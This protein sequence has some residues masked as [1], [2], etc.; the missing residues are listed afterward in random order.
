MRPDPAV[1]S[2]L[3]LDRDDVQSSRGGYARHVAS[4][5]IANPCASAV[6]ESRLA[7]VRAELAEDTELRMT[8]ARGEAIELA[9]E[10]SA[11]VDAVYVFGGDGTFN[12]VLNGIDAT[13]PVGFIPGG[14]TSVL[15]RALGLPKEPAAAARRV[16]KAARARR[17][18]VGRVNG[19]RFGFGAGVGIDAE[20]VR[21]VDELG[22]GEDGKRVSNLAFAWTGVRTL[23]RHRFRLEPALEVTGFGRAAFALVSNNP[24][25]SYA[26]RVPLQPAPEA[27]FEGGLDLVAPTRLRPRDLPRIARYALGRGNVQQARG[28]LYVHDADRLEVVCDRPLPLQAD[29]EDLGDVEQAVFEAERDAVLVLM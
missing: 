8:S 18:S 10:L 11:Q 2:P 5:L 17:I 27:T 19:R 16:A 9:R 3:S 23:S 12:E 25:Y 28:L 20:I 26:G 29:G 15:P 7:A 6:D 14:G 4:V 21:A 1:A 22:R 24:T 13:T